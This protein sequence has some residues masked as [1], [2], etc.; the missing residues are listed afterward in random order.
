MARV[1]DY[2]FSEIFPVERYSCEVRERRGFSHKSAQ[3]FGVHRHHN[4]ERGGVGVSFE[5]VLLKQ[6]KL[7]GAVIDAKWATRLDHKVARH[8]IDRYFVKFGNARASLRYLEQA[9][10]S[11]RSKIIASLR[12]LTDGGVLEVIRLGSGT[13]PTEYGLNFDFSSG[14]AEDTSNRGPSQET[15]TGTSPVTSTPLSGPPED[16]KTYLRDRLTSRST[17]VRLNGTPAVPASDLTADRAAGDPGGFEQLWSAWPRKHHRAKAQAAY[18]AL[19]PDAPLQDILVTR[20]ALWASHYEQTGMDKRWWKYLHT[21]IRDECYLEDLPIPYENPNERKPSKAKES[22]GP[23]STGKSGLSPKAPLG[24]HNVTVMAAHITKSTTKDEEH[25]HLNM[26]YRIKG[27]PHD[28]K[29]FS[30]S[31]VFDSDN[32]QMRHRGQ[33]MFHALWKAVDVSQPKEPSDFLNS[34]LVVRIGKLG[35]VQYGNSNGNSS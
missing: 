22:T 27:G 6:Y 2:L 9:T 18:K 34:S 11:T 17:E 10:G 20:A 15:A 30:H 19:N 24:E 29:E 26:V 21:W 7:L 12:R 13:R 35:R 23:Q 8:V 5:P 3:L 4:R 25:S 28:G 1:R 32:E 14:A 33:D 31:F 16:T